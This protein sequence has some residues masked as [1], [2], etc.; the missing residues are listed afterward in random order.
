MRSILL[1]ILIMPFDIFAQNVYKT[2]F[3][4]TESV[5][6]TN[7]IIIDP[8]ENWPRFPGGENALYCF[9]EHSYDY[10]ILNY[11]GKRGRI[12]TK[13]IINK[14]GFVENIEINPKILDS[15]LDLVHDSL[16]YKEI[17]RVLR[18]MPRWEPATIGDSAIS[19]NFIL[20]IRLP[21]SDFKCQELSSDSI[22]INFDIMPD[23]KYGK[24]H[25]LYERL[26]SFINGHLQWPR[27][28]AD[29]EGSAFIQCTVECDGRLNKFKIIR[30]L[31]Y[32]FD[33]E[34]LRVI[35]L[36]PNWNPAIKGGK[37]VRS[38]IVI[39]VKFKIQ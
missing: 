22:V 9:L 26:N 2:D 6:S 10:N 25:S 1:I 35:R 27:T 17:T 8:I 37:P 7:D 29:C 16:I 23:Y 19:C 15:C 13:F 32:D 18:K 5:N 14:E 12:F 4:S 28:E 11:R 39:P 34:A 30:S 21:Y 31:G 3:T 33:S 20:P 38:V 36:M 24:E